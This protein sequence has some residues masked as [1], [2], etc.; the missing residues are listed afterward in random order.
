MRNKFFDWGFLPTEEYP[1]PVVCVGNLAMGGTGKTPHIEYLIRLLQPKFRVAVLSRGYK[2]SSKGYLLATPE[3]KMSEIGDE[4]YQIKQKFPQVTVAVDVNRRHG[5]RTMMN[6]A[7]GERPEVILL[8]DAFQHR[9]VTPSL[10]IVLTD[11]NRLYYHDKMFPVGRLREQQSGIV[12][13]QA[14]IVTNCDP[15]LKPIDFRIIEDDM[16]L[17]AYQHI[18][19]SRPNYLAVKSVWPELAG[20]PFYEISK[21]DRVVLVTGIANPQPLIDEIQSRSDNVSPL[22]FPDHHNFTKNDVLR[23]TSL[24]DK[25]EGDKKIILVTEKDEARLRQNPYLKDEYKQFLF[26]IPIAIRFCNDHEKNFNELVMKEIDNVN[27]NII[28]R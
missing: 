25:Q 23:I 24:F 14:V 4:A 2:R 8:D 19:F 22:V 26:S 20:T 1:I 15:D 3:T 12:R 5:I 18:F 10:A 9:Y 27:N 11:Y 17:A 28:A 13:A 21:S 16:K 7:P 6:M